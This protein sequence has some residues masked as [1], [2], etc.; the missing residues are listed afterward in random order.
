MTPIKRIGIYAV[1]YVRMWKRI[2]ALLLL[3]IAL[4]TFHWALQ[5][6]AEAERVSVLR[7]ERNA[8][9]ARSDRLEEGFNRLVSGKEV[10]ITLDSRYYMTACKA[11][12][13]QT[14]GI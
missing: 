2:V 3:V 4:I 14:A 13:F 5:D 1:D 8:A 9:I 12:P 11:W 10:A 7:M 6:I